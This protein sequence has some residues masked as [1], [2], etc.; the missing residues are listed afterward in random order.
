MFVRHFLSSKLKTFIP[1]NL[2]CCYSFER[3]F[4]RRTSKT[5]KSP[6][7]VYNCNIRINE[8]AREGKLQSA[9]KVFDEMLHRDVVSWNSMITAYWQNGC[10]SESKKLFLSMPERTVVSWN[11]MIAGC[12]E[13]D[14]IDDAYLYFS[15]MPEKN[16]ASWNAMISGYVK[17]GMVEEAARLFDEMPRKNVISYTATIDGYMRRRE[18]DKARSLFDRMPQKNE[19]S[20]TVMINGYVENECF[21]EAKELFEKMPAKNKNVV[22]ITAMVIGY[23]KEGRV[24]EG[25]ILFDGILCKDSV[26]YNAMIS[27]YAQNGR[28]EEALKLLV[29][30]LRMSLRPDQSS[31]ASVLSACAALASP[32]VGRQ[33]HAVVIKFGVDSVVSICN[34]LITMYSKCGSIFECE[35]AFELIT[36]PDLVSWNTIIAAFAQHGLYAKAVAYLEQMVLRGCEPDGI[37]FLSLLSAC[38]HAGL[39]SESISW[40]DSMVKNYNITLRPEHYACL[41]DILGRAGQLDKAYNIIQEMPFEADL[42]AWGALLA[43]CRAHSNVELGQLAGEKVM[44]LGGD[45][46]GPYIMLSNIYAEA[47]MWG[48]VTR[49]RGLMKEHGIKKKPAYSWTEIENK[50]HYFLGGDISHPN[51]QE[52]RTA[53]KWMNLQMKFQEK[54]LD[55]TDFYFLDELEC[56]CI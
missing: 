31:C 21:D 23:C 54:V 55:F 13:N 36:S 17:H 34:A 11:S 52:I 42:A 30:M 37:T 40:F 41:I 3:Y 49:V 56:T 48:E 18:I 4:S 27:G 50:V 6:Q 1:L 12:V 9:R 8:L 26:A 38:A 7:D 45:S 39:V 2:P 28:N 47:G 35:L 29:E 32:L 5:S 22:A 19:V 53:L 25:R 10:L 20:W 24:E 15:T 43:G 44:E 33:T 46:S 14:C 16:V 51:I